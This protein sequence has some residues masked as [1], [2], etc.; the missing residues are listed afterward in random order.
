MAIVNGCHSFLIKTMDTSKLLLHK[1]YKVYG[2]LNVESRLRYTQCVT[3]H[4]NNEMT[5]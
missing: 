3:N 1:Q 4:F 2:V 5:H